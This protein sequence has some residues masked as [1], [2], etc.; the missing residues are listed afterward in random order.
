MFFFSTDTAKHQSPHS[1][2]PMFISDMY[3]ALKEL[4][5]LHKTNDDGT[6]LPCTHTMLF[7]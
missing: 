3:L 6:Y 1:K 5:R 4:I 7:A 2:T